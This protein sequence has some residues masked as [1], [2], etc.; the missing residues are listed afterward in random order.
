MSGVS[1][2]F[3]FFNQVFGNRY[4]FEGYSLLFSFIESQFVISLFCNQLRKRY[5]FWIRIIMMLGAGSVFCY[6]LAILNTEHPAMGVRVL[7]YLLINV[8]NLV[9]VAVC[10][11][12]RTD[13]RLY[14]FSAGLSAYQIGNKFYPLLQNL[15]GINDRNTISLFSSEIG[16]VQNWE[17][18]VFYSVRFLTYLLLWLAFRPRE[19]LPEDKKVRRNV[20]IISLITVAVVNVLVCVARLY[21]AE[22]M[23]LSIVIKIFTI[24]FSFVVLVICAGLLTGSENERQLSILNQLM[25]QEKAQFDSVKANMDAINMRCHDLKHMIDKLEGKLTGEEVDALREASRFYDANIHT[26][27][28]VLDIVLCEKAILCDKSGIRFSCMAEGES[29]KFLT[30]AQTYSLFGNIIDNAIE[31]LRRV[32]DPEQKVIS[33]VCATRDGCPVIEETNYFTGTL[34]FENGLPATIKEDR[35]RHGFGVKSIRYIAELHG[36]KLEMHT[37][38]NMFFLTVSFPRQPF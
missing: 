1:V 20:T 24:S 6:L 14:A 38:E 28:E 21:E 17:I 36:G 15:R 3:D 9:F 11:E 19:P 7:C 33:L 31:A 35:G 34:V 32:E 26:G 27:N 4:V 2:M 10:W 18:I 37:V 22:S 8:L 30:A 25:K 29:F 12:G 5:G 16:V 13:E 23:A